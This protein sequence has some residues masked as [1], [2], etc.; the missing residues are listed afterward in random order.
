MPD[1]ESEIDKTTHPAADAP[2]SEGE[3][4]LAHLFRMSTTSVAGQEYVAI[5]PTSI[6]ALLLGVASVL[7]LVADLMLIIPLAGVICAI[8]AIV[9]IRRSNGTQTG[10]LFA[11]AG[12][13]IALLIGG[14]RA[15]QEVAASV[16]DR[17]ESQNIAAV[18]ERFGRGV[19]AARY[20]E[21]YDD[22]TTQAFRE[23]IDRNNFAVTLQQIQTQPGY[24][25]VDSIEW[26]QQRMPFQEVGTS[27]NR[28]A[29]AMGIMKF[30]KSDFI[31]RP[32][33]T[34][35]N[36]EGTWKIDSSSMFVEKKRKRDQE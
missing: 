33:F 24:G 26:N 17:R 13:I 16:R 9:Q 11:I 23:R 18:M 7:A 19:H 36:R 31:G 6:V 34:F 4:P 35:S 15:G 30:R 12:L 3:D 29:S 27:G 28:A 8:V 20:D 5:N 25:P 21:I 2:G 32:V 10:R 1:V 22:M 14:A